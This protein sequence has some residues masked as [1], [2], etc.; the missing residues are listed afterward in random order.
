MIPMSPHRTKGPGV[1]NATSSGSIGPFGRWL[2]D[3]G[4]R[5]EVALKGEPTA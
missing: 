2:G 3:R 1:L 5:P 4:I